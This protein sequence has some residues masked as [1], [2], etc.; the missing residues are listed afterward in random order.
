M[1]RSP[2]LGFNATKLFWRKFFKRFDLQVKVLDK[3]LALFI[4]K[5]RRQL[6]N[7]RALTDLHHVEISI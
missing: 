4:L 5:L 7:F 6:R 1:I 2:F 3:L